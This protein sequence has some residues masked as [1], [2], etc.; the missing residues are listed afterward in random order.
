MF[1]A[2]QAAALANIRLGLRPG[3]R[4]CLA[5]WQ[6]LDANDWLTIPG[7]A[8]LRYSNIPDTETGGP[9]MFAQSDANSVTATLHA[10]GY[11]DPQREPVQ[12]TLALGADPNEAVDYLAGTGPGRA[13]LDSVPDDG[14]PPWSTN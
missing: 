10:A 2:D 6:P 13:A 4:L 8:L 9:G 1:F 14:L 11:A 5:T 12:L 7:A 3:G